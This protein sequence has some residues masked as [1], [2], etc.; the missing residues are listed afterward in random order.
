MHGLPERAQCFEKMAQINHGSETPQPGSMSK[1]R[2]D[3]GRFQL[4]AEL[5][6]P[7]P[8]LAVD[9]ELV[10]LAAKPVW[11]DLNT[12]PIILPSQGGAK[13]GLVLGLTFTKRPSD[14]AE[15]PV[16]SFSRQATRRGRDCNPHCR[17]KKSRRTVKPQMP[18]DRDI[19]CA[20]SLIHI[21]QC[22]RPACKR[23]RHEQTV[24][25]VAGCIRMMKR[26]PVDGLL[27]HPQCA[28]HGFDATKPFIPR[29]LPVGRQGQRDMQ[30]G[31][32]ESAR[33]LHLFK[34]V[35]RVP[36]AAPKNRATYDFGT[37][38]LH[39]T[40]QTIPQDRVGSLMVCDIGACHKNPRVFR[41]RDTSFT[42]L[43]RC[44]DKRCNSGAP[45]APPSRIR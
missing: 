25:V 4:I 19:R 3:R 2:R 13:R 17:R 18:S 38:P 29:Q 11:R 32:P 43:E 6:A 27:R 31:F 23:K 7:E 5:C 44:D 9:A 28:K 39:G 12:D 41:R 42:N 22:D 34:Q 1:A 10:A 24:D 14:S 40:A 20:A 35:D 33:H 15:D 36:E 8:G 26:K 37:P 21:G 30:V 45:V 16:V